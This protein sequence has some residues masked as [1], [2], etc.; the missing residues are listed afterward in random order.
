MKPNNVEILDLRH[1]L[2]LAIKQSLC[3]HIKNFREMSLALIFQNCLILLML[4]PI[5]VKEV[6]KHKIQA[7]FSMFTQSNECVLSSK[8]I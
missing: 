1:L 5:S 3:G 7:N 6:I 8:R 4:S 2:Y